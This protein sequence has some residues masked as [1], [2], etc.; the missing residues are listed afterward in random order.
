M[1]IDRTK[2][3]ARRIPPLEVLQELLD[4]LQGIESIL[5]TARMTI[6]T[7]RAAIVIRKE[8]H[9]S[10][11][12]TSGMDEDEEL[13]GEDDPMEEGDDDYSEVPSISTEDVEVA[14]DELLSEINLKLKASRKREVKALGDFF[15]RFYGVNSDITSSA[16][17]FE[18]AINGYVGLLFG[19]DLERAN[20][21]L[22]TIIE[23]VGEE[24]K[25]CNQ[26]S[27]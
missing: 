6:A 12:K 1:V 19:E 9:V 25:Q 2:N 23:F 17:E 10:P 5:P 3:R 4:Q 24:I 14:V 21:E 22:S 13:D 7:S 8:E 26:L 18:D 11:E 15:A 16:L 20:S 27:L